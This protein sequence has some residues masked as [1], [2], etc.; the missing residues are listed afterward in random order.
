MIL[1]VCWHSCSSLWG[2][3]HIWV[4]YKFE[5]SGSYQFLLLIYD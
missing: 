5:A 3:R 1:Y 2:N 4:L